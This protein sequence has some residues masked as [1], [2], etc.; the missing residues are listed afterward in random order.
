MLQHFTRWQYLTVWPVA[1]LAI[2]ML[3][4]PGLV[5]PLVFAWLNGAV[6]FMLVFTMLLW[7]GSRQDR[8]IAQLL[9]DVDNEQSRR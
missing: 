4:V 6:L 7:N 2:W 3:C 5:S 9:H 1:A 8:T